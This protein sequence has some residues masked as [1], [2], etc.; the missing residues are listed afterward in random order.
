VA[1]HPTWAEG[2]NAVSDC[3]AKAAWPIIAAH[4]GVAASI[5]R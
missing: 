5:R 3:F 4:A 1:A 2:L